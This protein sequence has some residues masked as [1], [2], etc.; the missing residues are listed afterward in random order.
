MLKRPRTG[1]YLSSSIILS[2]P[3]YVKVLRD[4]I[5][6]NLVI[7]GFSGE[8]PED[9]LK[10]SPYDGS[11]PSD[12]CL[13]GLVA[14]HLDGEPVDRS[15]LPQAGSS[16]G[17]SAGRGGSNTDF[18]RAVRVAREAGCEVWICGGSWTLRGL[19]FCPSNT[20][21]RD[22][23]QALYT[24]WSTSCEVD[25]IDITHARYPMVS[26]PRGLGACVCPACEA[27]AA[28][29]GYDFGNL[30]VAA[31]TFL[32]DLSQ[33]D[34]VR[35]VTACRGGAGPMDF[36]QI[37]GMDRGLLDWFRFRCDLL[38]EGIACFRDAV[39]AA[40][41]PDF[42][43]GSDTYPASLSLFVG[44]DHA[45]WAECSDFA[46]PLVS[47]VQQFVCLGLIALS[48]ILREHLPA[49]TEEEALHLVYA[50]TGYHGLGLP[51]S[52]ADYHAEDADELARSIPLRDV[53]RHDLAKARLAL[54]A[55]IPSYPII[56]GEGWP[57]EDIDAIRDGAL[58]L[59]HDGVMWQGTAELVDFELK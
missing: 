25:G 38:T 34:P 43:F 39:H 32:Q 2:N 46:S 23:Y 30:R 36:T 56:H 50:A 18:R 22:W 3:D 37:L 1:I 20:A 53:I 8:L 13:Q 27:R 29:L 10:A 54:P 45:R 7:L 21:V 5:G 17:P 26:F 44:H 28:D 55:D 14:R 35:L 15:E 58:A 52:V 31:D 51:D 12:D 6:L 24:H 19:M 40:A 49:L 16:P 11:P 33:L 57:R 42:V 59:G 9:V 48:R 41:G 47:H 4:E